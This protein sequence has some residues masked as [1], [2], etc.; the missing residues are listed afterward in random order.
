MKQVQIHPKDPEVPE[1]ENEQK[2]NNIYIYMKIFIDNKFRSNQQK[3]GPFKKG[4][5]VRV[6][7]NELPPKPFNDVN[8]QHPE[9]FE[10]NRDKINKLLK[11]WKKLHIGLRGKVIKVTKSHVSVKFGVRGDKPKDK[12]M[13]DFSKANIYNHLFKLD[14]DESSSDDESDHHMPDNSGFQKE[15]DEALGILNEGLDE[16]NNLQD[17]IDRHLQ[18]IPKKSSRKKLTKKNK[19]K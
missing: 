11:S 8:R 10:K 12:F 17:E 5:I 13:Y 6:G 15:L 9:A 2:K 19:N 18:N 1:N 14:Y 3:K 16:I 4:D 7:P